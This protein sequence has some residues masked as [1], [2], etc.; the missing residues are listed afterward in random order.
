MS[1]SARVPFIPASRPASRA[2]HL[3]DQLQN[4]SKSKVN[5][6]FIVNVA[7]PLHTSSNT[8]LPKSQ[9]SANGV[10]QPPATSLDKPLNTGGLLKK[11]NPHMGPGPQTPSI[12][13]RPSFPGSNAITR[14]GTADSHSSAHRVQNQ[15]E[16]SL[17]VAAP[18]P[19]QATRPSSPALS[20]NLASGVFSLAPSTTENPLLAPSQPQ[21]I[22]GSA[23]HLKDAH[24][25]A[26]GLGFSFGKTHT[27]TDQYQNT[28]QQLPSPPNSIKTSGT[29]VFE[30]FSTVDLDRPIP[31]LPFTLNMSLPNQTGPQRIPINSDGTRSNLDDILLDQ[32]PNADNSRHGHRHGKRPNQD[33][34]LKRPRDELEHD[35]KN[36][37]ESDNHGGRLKKY[38]HSTVG[39][40]FLLFPCT[41]LTF[42]F[43]WSQEGYIHRSQPVSSPT[44]PSSPDDAH[45][46]SMLTPA[47]YSHN[48]HSHVPSTPPQDQGRNQHRDQHQHHCEDQDMTM[49][50]EGIE[51][52][53]TLDKLLGCDTDT[54]IEEHMETYQRAVSRWRECSMEEWIAGADGKRIYISLKA[55]RHGSLSAHNYRI[56]GK[57]C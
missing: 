33:K 8:Q 13:R 27:S 52:S 7:N 53:R 30:P 21:T 40:Y 20:T 1:S 28:S 2:A 54:Y 36:Q 11:R 37:E 57:I 12:S 25:P 35:E 16:Q 48:N 51:G 22:P 18:V 34:Q 55:S 5:P 14:P 42:S 6:Q 49:L 56:G 10:S 45:T 41:R 43:S 17:K 9:N 46:M 32:V 15:L 23:Q 31:R 24:T 44:Q 26:S 4:T 29:G 39:P 47:E 19:R 3:N 50:D 38:K